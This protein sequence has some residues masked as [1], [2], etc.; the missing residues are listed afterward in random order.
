[1]AAEGGK[2]GGGISSRE[3]GGEKGGE[4][5]DESHPSKELNKK[6]WCGGGTRVPS[7]HAGGKKALIAT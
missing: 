1:M 3:E 4:G 6:T 2:G 5:G 7:A